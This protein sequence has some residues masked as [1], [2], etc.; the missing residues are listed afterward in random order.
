MDLIDKLKY[1]SNSSKPKQEP[2]TNSNLYE[3]ASKLNGFVFEENS[4]P[5][6]KR[7]FSY[8]FKQMQIEDSFQTFLKLPVLTKG[9]FSEPI[10]IFDILF[11]DLETTGLAGG[12]GTYPF[13]IGIAFFEEE[14]FTVIQYFLPE[15]DRDVF[16]YID[17]KNYV[18]FKS[19]LGS[20]N[21]K[22]YDYPLLKN[23]FILN[24]FENL[25]KE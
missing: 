13:L 22:S 11:F 6:I 15:Y 5:I 23:R 7:E 16:A 17:I 2:Q 10:N 3:L 18:Q 4:L 24:R 20:F 1:Y 19:I 12:A 21:G 8:S 25:F 14:K 9:D